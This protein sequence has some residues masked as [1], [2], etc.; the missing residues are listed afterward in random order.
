MI[1]TIWLL[2]AGIIVGVIALFLITF[3]LNKR[4]KVPEGIDVPEKC[5]VCQSDTCL[6]KINDVNKIKATLKQQIEE[7]CLVEEEVNNEKK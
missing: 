4:T 2:Q 6:I 5:Q 1:L 7:D 3:I